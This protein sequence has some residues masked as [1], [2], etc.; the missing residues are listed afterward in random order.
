MSFSHFGRANGHLLLR[1]SYPSNHC[2]DPYS[3]TASNP[4]D[5]TDGGKRVTKGKKG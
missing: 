2:S 5:N 4:Q 1:G 3:A